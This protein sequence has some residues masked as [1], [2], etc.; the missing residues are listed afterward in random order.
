MN[1][2]DQMAVV[3]KQWKAP[4]ELGHSTPRAV[5]LSSSGIALAALAAA[6]AIGALV[7]AVLAGRESTRQTEEVEELERDGEDADARIVR[8]WRTRGEGN[9]YRVEYWFRFEG[10]TY[11][12]EMK[13]PQR[14][15]K[16]L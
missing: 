15:W 16:T 5:R 10:R 9:H 1:R 6:L 4:A 3:Q 2:Y 7:V 11:Q 12:K 14:I 13:I 8:L